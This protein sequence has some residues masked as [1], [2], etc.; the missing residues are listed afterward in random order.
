MN[1]SE[2]ITRL[3]EES[4]SL[5][6]GGEVAAAIQRAKHARQ[7][8]QAQADTDGEA[9]A[10]NA[11]AYAHIRLGHY[12]QAQQLCAQALALAGVESPTRA[13]ALLNSGICAG[14]TDDMPASE[15]FIQQAIDLSRQIGYDHILVRGLHALSCGIYMP[16]GQFALALA[17]DEEALNIARTR[18]LQELTWGPLLTMSWVHWLTGQPHLADAR[19]NELRLSVSPGSLGD[20]YW[21]FIQASLALDAGEIEAAKGLFTK[22]LSIAEANGI[23]E[24]LYLAYL[25]MSRINRAENDV[26]A[27][28]AWASE[29]L[30]IVERTG[31]HHLQGQALIE[32]SR[33]SWVLGDL[34]IAEADLRTAIERLAPQRLEFDLSIAEL[35]LAALLQQQNRPETAATWREAAVRLV[36]GGFVFLVDR[37]RSLSFPL[38]IAGLNSLDKSI[39]EASKALLE[40]LQHV[41]PPPIKITTFGGWRVQVGARVVDRQALRQRCSGELLGLLLISPAR[42]ISSDQVIDALWPE[43]ESNATQTLF[44]HATSALR[45]ALEPD[46]PEKFPSRYVEVSDGR[47]TLRLPP[48]S[49]VDFETFTGH[50]RRG[51]WGATLTCY[52]GEFLPQYRYADWAITKRQRLVQ[53]YQ[54]ALLEMA[55]TWLV[56][57]RLIETL[58][59]CRKIL[60]AEPWHEQAVLLGMRACL[61]MEN[62]PEALRLYKTLKKKLNDELGIEPQVELQT[63]YRS[64]LKP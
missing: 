7:L 8:A 10:L 46:L 51:E 44:H 53:D 35:L 58:D 62:R 31:Y 29:A 33:A 12:D 56:E 54:H 5:E 17:V 27:A 64:L 21:H 25:G 50:H 39:E 24:N 37:E 14:E 59:A 40:H 9:G 4:R 55:K 11:L 23:A 36:R 63:L 15:K 20:G 30:T 18:G 60:A 47:V 45:R 61:R 48:S 41:P 34:A 32:R 57:D 6:R 49:T 42:T 52:S 43:K 19:L 13:E 22:T 38:I 2:K 28:L 1:A 26:P 16:R 3:I